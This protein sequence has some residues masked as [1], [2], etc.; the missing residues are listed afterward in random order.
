MGYL[1]G[2]LATL[3]D[4]DRFHSLWSAC[5]LGNQL[6]E[7]LVGFAFYEEREGNW[8]GRDGGRKKLPFVRHSLKL[9]LG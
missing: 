7:L 2:N 5:C 4:S 9:L 6:N 3:S 8:D 1:S